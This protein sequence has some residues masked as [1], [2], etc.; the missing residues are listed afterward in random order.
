MQHIGHLFGHLVVTNRRN[1]SIYNDIVWVYFKDELMES[2]SLRLNLFPDIK[3]HIPDNTDLSLWKVKD[4]QWI[5]DCPVPADE[6]FKR[7]A[8]LWEVE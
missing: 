7:V 6:E 3:K 4:M 2:K 5:K 1:F 8:E